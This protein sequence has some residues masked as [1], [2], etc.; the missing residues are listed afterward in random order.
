[1]RLAILSAL[2]KLLRIRF[3]V[4]GLPYGA[5]LTNSAQACSASLH[6]SN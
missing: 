2:A 6:S 4:D 1:M 5:A 3:R